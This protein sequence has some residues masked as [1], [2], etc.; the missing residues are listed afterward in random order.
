MIE[1][2]EPRPVVNGPGQEGE[3]SIVTKT[4]DKDKDKLNLKKPGL[5]EGTG[6]GVAARWIGKI[7]WIGLVKDF[8]REVRIELKKVTWPSRKETIAATAMVILLSVLV[9]FFLGLLD[10]GLAKAVGIILKR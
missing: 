4:K 10:V 5:K 1:T 9:A 3:V 7:Q 8:L 6:E 2:P